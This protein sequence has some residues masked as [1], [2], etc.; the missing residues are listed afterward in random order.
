MECGKQ[1]SFCNMPSK[2]RAQNLMK[3]LHQ[4]E[5]ENENF[6]TVRIDYKNLGI[7]SASHG[8]ELLEK[9]RLSEKDIHFEFS[10]K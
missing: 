2:Y 6:I 1:S 7:G 10:I 8:P 5:L 9:Y 3:A 4:D